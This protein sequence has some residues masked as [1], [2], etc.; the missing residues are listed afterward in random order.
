MKKLILT[1]TGVLILLATAS[2]ESRIFLSLG[3]NLISPSDAAYKDIYGN[4]VLY[5]EGA[6]AIRTIGGLCVTGSYGQF[7]R[8]GTTPDLGLPTKSKQGYLSAGLG[9][10]QRVSSFLCVQGSAGVASI[11]FREEALDT[12]VSGNKMGFM[13]E[14]G[15]FLMP[16]AQNFFLGLKV[17]Y[18]SASVSDVAPDIAGAQPVKLGGLKV[19]VCVGIQLFGSH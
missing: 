18:L 8:K 17:G 11:S 7:A 9:Y 13:A 5:P 10:L 6:L 4:H 15:A 16:E 1:L 14:A 3:A 2:A 12:V 19:C